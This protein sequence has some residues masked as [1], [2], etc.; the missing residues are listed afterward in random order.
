MSHNIMLLPTFLQRRYFIFPVSVGRFSDDPNHRIYRSQGAINEFNIHFV[1]AGKGYVESGGSIHTLQA[2]DA[3]LFFPLEEQRYYTSEDDPWDV[4]WVHFYGDRLKEF[5]I[6]HG[7][8]RSTI[9]SLGQLRQITEAHGALYEEALQHKILHET[10]LSALTYS[11]LV[12]FM[13]QAIP[14]SDVRSGAGGTRIPELLPLMQEKAR[15]PFDLAYWAEQTGV[16]SFYFCKLFRKVT[17]MTPLAFVTLCR[18]QFGKQ[19]LLEQ[20]DV[21]VK[22]IAAEAGYSSASYFNKKFIEHEG[23]T[24]SEFRELYVKKE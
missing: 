21:P 2:G 9:W 18:I 19:R 11:F 7:F 8:H 3:F 20:P 1:V 22:Q 4:R 15:E 14:L 12:E 24:P 5:M 6:E 10:K 23:M 17:R 13:G 16:S